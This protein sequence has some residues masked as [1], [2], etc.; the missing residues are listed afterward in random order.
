MSLQEAT[1]TLKCRAFHLTLSGEA[2]RWQAEFEALQSY[3]S[4]F[5]DEMLFYERITDAEAFF[6]LKGGLDMNFHFWRDV[7]N[8]NSTMFDQLVKMI[9]EE[10]T[11]ENMI[12]Y[13]NRGGVAPN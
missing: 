6:A 5:N 3:P 13:R 11:N 4:H 2:K 12:L 1:P 9:T 10:I 8:K 7:R